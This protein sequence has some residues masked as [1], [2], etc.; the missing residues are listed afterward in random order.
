MDRYANLPRFPPPPKPSLPKFPMSKN[1]PKLILRFC[2]AP[3]PIEV[4]FLEVI[5]VEW[6]LCLVREGRVIVMPEDAGFEACAV[7]EPS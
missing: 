3:L 6:L 7:T 1:S 4:V 5:R 2:P